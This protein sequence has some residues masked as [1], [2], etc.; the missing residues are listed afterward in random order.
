MTSEMITRLI[1]QTSHATTEYVGALLP[2]E[3]R[4]MLVPVQP[5]EP[6]EAFRQLRKAMRRTKTENAL[7]GLYET[8]APIEHQADVISLESRRRA[9]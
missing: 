8:D 1:M 6:W 4:L 5:D 9:G 7:I 3:S 2:E